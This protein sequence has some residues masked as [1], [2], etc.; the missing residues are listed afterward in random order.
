M[1]QRRNKL[2]LGQRLRG[3]FWPHIGWRRAG[4]YL[5][6]RLARLPGTPHS[7][8]GGFAIGAAMCFTPFV[9]LQLVMSAI[10]A[11]IIRV[12]VIASVLGTF[13]GN[14]WTFPFIWWLVYTTGTI[15]LGQDSVEALP[16]TLGIA[17]VFDNFLD[18]FLPMLVGSVPIGIIVWLIFYLP[19][20]KLVAGYQAA[21][22]ERLK[23]KAD[24]NFTSSPGNQH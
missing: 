4:I 13:V 3:F 23:G 15:I 5:K 11:G 12:S 6:H 22:R 2:T 7:I 20:R 1:F 19:L 16:E 9:G 10:L 24:G 14:P 18:I 17:Y 21:R 8:A